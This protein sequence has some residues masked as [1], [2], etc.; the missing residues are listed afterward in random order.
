[1]ATTNKCAY[2]GATLLSTDEVCPQCGA[3]NP[4]YQAPKEEEHQIFQPRTIEELKQYCAE[5][6]MP[7]LRMR[8]FIGDDFR[9]PKAFGIYEENGR[10]IVYKNK[11]DGTRAIRYQGEDEEYAVN[12]IFEKLL[13]ECHSRGIYP[14]GKP[15]EGV[16]IAKQRNVFKNIFLIASIVMML[17]FGLFSF[18]DK[19]HKNDGYYQFGNGTVYYHYGDD[20]FYDSADYGWIE[21][22][23]PS[24][25]GDASE[26]F[27]GEDYTSDWGVSDFRQSQIYE[28]M[29]SSESS[30]YS[31]WDT[32]DTDWDSDW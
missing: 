15:E 6:N 11:A 10:Y 7:L 12:E 2:C 21:T 25:Q 13:D 27:L 1:M 5:R 16:R 14:D 9:E 17:T 28:E 19:S 22:D 30:D 20:W 32:S 3:P 4:N 23:A 31:D 18:F 26:Y 8:F 29:H 24:Y